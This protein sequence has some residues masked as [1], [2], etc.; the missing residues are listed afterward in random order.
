MM[1]ATSEEAIHRVWDDLSGFGA[2]HSTQAVLHLL[3]FLCETV[4]AWNATWAGAVRLEGA[5]DTDPLQG[6]RVGAVQALHAIPPH[7]DEGHFKD[8]L[9]V[10]DKREIDPSFLLPMQRVGAFRS[11]SFRRELPASWFESAFYQRYYASVGTVDALFVAFP[12]NKDCESHVGLY[13]Q[14]TFTDEQ[15]AKLSYALRGI[16]WFHRHMMLSYGLVVASSPLT[17]AERKVMQLLLTSASE[18]D[19]ARQLLLSAA[20]VHQYIVGI[21]RKFGV[22]SR[23][24]LMALWLSCSS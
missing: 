2:D 14:T 12:L 5:H 24:G 16:K 4:G 1:T 13:A 21:F 15:I 8:I 10:W 3:S 18:K 6:W 9:E 17:P 19:I 7:P 11:Y 22:H 23:A 20:T